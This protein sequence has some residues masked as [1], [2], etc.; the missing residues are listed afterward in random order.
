MYCVLFIAFAFPVFKL[1]NRSLVPED[2]L[3]CLYQHIVNSR[4]KRDQL[5]VTCFLVSIFNAQH[6]SDVNTF[7]FRSLRLIC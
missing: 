2:K 1:L 3:Y 6:V 4:I 5:D 7:I